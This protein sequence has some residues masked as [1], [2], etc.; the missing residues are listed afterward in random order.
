VD[1]LHEEHGLYSKVIDKLK[2]DETLYESVRKVA[3]QIADAHLWED[4]EKARE[5]DK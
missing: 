1:E 4:G 3:L 5:A 2:A